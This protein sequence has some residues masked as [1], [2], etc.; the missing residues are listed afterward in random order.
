MDDAIKAI[1]QIVDEM[2]QQGWEMVSSNV[3]CNQS[4]AVD[5]GKTGGGNIYNLNLQNGLWGIVCFHET[6]H[7]AVAPGVTFWWPPKPSPRGGA[8]HRSLD[9]YWFGIAFRAYPRP[10]PS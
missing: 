2:G 3:Y 8:N 10:L 5:Y 6:A 1:R 7:R 9:V 4:K